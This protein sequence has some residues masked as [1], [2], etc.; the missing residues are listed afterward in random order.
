MPTIRVLPDTLANQIAAGEVVERPAS[1]VKELVENALDAGAT[2]IDV[3][4]EQAGLGRIK[5]TDNGHGMS[6]QQLP[7]ALARHATSKITT[8]EDLFNIHTFGFRGEALPSMASVAYVTITSRASGAEQAWQVNE[9]N[10]VRPAALSQGTVVEVRDLF[11][12]TPA[13]RKFL[14][15]ER[16]ENQQIEATV[17]RLALAHPGVTFTL[18]CDGQEKLHIDASQSDLLDDTLA[19]LA[20][21]MGKEFQANAV[22]IETTRDQIHLTG[23]VSLPTYNMG[24]NRRQYLFVNGRPVQ[25]KTLLSALRQAYHDRLAKGRHPLAVLFLN[26]PHDQVD[27]NVHPAKAEVRFRHGRDIYGLIYSAIRHALDNAGATSSSVGANQ[28]LQAFQAP[29]QG[30]F[31]QP[32]FTPMPVS[33]VAEAAPTSGFSTPPHLMRKGEATPVLPQAAEPPQEHPLGAAVGQ[34]HST[35]IVAQNEEGL[36]LVD[37]HAAHERILYEKFKQHLHGGQAPSQVLLVPEVVELHADEVQALLDRQTELAQ[38]GLEIDQLGP[39][40]ITVRAV[41]ALLGEVNAAAMVKD[42][43]EDMLSMKHATTLQERLEETVSTMACHGSIRANRRLS[44]DEM[45]ALLRQMEATPN[46]AQCNHGRPTYV[47]LQ[48]LDIEKLFG[49]R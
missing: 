20:S 48:R 2:R 8:T 45:N 49:R 10:D 17:T 11:Y 16:A 28:A 34:V 5:V 9:K 42:L 37:Q 1:I 40:A 31:S 27:V 46:S 3:A 44:V 13:R 15:S 33:M 14:K 29:Q 47:T 12:A 22:P 6:E 26:V 19:R 24:S 32:S 39:K 21:I 4:T 23:F 35:Y 18:S 41:P 43:V 36:V 7:L 30:S 25:D 38:F